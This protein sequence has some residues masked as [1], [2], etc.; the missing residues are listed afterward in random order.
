MSTLDN[1]LGTVRDWITQMRLGNPAASSPIVLP[2]NRQTL[3]IGPGEILEIAHAADPDYRRLVSLVEQVFEAGA[4]LIPVMTGP[5]SD[6]CAISASSHYS[7]ATAPWRAAD[8]LSNTHWSINAGQLTGWWRCCFTTPQTVAGYAITAM[9][10]YGDSCPRDWTLRGSNDGV[11]WTVL[12]A[13]AGT[14]WSNGQ[15]RAF[16]LAQPATF[17]CWEI[18]ITGAAR[19][20]YTTALAMAEVQLHAPALARILVPPP[21]DYR[22]EYLADRTRIQRLA[23]ERRQLTATVRL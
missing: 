18:H 16:T 13:R 7:E 4:N 8:G 2:A 1:R 6:L 22:I 14:T 11:N 12:D 19:P 20:D 21:Q 5:V 23:A 9:S 15:R 3:D 17:S 10:P